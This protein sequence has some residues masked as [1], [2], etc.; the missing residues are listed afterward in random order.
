[1]FGKQR[2]AKIE[3]QRFEQG[4]IHQQSLRVSR[5]TRKNLFGE[6]IEDV[7]FRLL[8][9]VMQVQRRGPVCRMHLLFG[10]LAYKLKCGYPSLRSS[11]IL[12][13]LFVF[14]LDVERLF[15]QLFHFFVGEEQIVA[16]DHQRSR[17]RFP[18]HGRERRKVAG[19]YDHMDKVR[20]IM[21]EPI[22]ELVND[23]IAAD[24]VIVIQ[25]KDK[26]LLDRLKNLVYQQVGR[27]F[28]KAKHLLVSFAQVW[29][30]SF[31]ECR[32]EILDTLR[33]ITEKHDWVCVSVVELVPNRRPYLAANKVSDQSG[34]AASGIRRN[35]G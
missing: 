8:Q 31:A 2:A 7:A 20:R 27:S 35:H 9:N 24:M 28:R 10:N 1:M 30:D 23:G 4:K 3:L 26:W 19:R 6:I 18:P 22:D 13:Y 14:Q 34:F 15:E 29:K 12:G 25:H 11:A 16:R 33:Y 17:L 5:L 32:I 21:Q